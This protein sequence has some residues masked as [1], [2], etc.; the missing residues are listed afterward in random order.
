MEKKIHLTEH[1]PDAMLH[2]ELWRCVHN[3]AAFVLL[4]G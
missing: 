4:C 2:T 3:E 1:F